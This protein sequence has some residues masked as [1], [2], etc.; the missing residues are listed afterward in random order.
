[1]DREGLCGVEFEKDDRKWGD[2]FL[3]K[4]TFLLTDLILSTPPRYGKKIHAIT[5]SLSLALALT[6]ITGLPHRRAAP[7]G[8]KAWGGLH[9]CNTRSSHL[10]YGSLV[11]WGNPLQEK[12]R[13]RGSVYRNTRQVSQ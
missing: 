4:V 9:F 13:P 11:I 5:F 8:G 10:H 2:C 12:E 1:M 7:V 6:L 3:L